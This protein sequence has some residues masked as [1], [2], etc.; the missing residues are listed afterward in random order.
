MPIHDWSHVDANL[1]HDFHQTWSVAIRTRL[2]NGCRYRKIMGRGGRRCVESEDLSL[3]LRLDVDHGYL[4]QVV[5]CVVKE[6]RGKMLTR[7]FAPGEIR[8]ML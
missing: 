8:A 7:R 6:K 3:Q 1:F 5:N 4:C 2:N